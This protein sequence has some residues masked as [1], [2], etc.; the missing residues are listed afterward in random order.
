MLCLCVIAFG[1]YALQADAPKVLDAGAAAAAKTQ[2]SS[3]AARPTHLSTDTNHEPGTKPATDRSE[4]HSLEP[5]AKHS[6][7]SERQ[8][9]VTTPQ[10]AE[11]SDSVHALTADD[12][13]VVKVS[14]PEPDVTFKEIDPAT[15]SEETI[16]K[17]A[18]GD[19]SRY[20]FVEIDVASLREKISNL[21]MDDPLHIELFPG[22]VVSPLPGT[23]EESHNVGDDIL[24]GGILNHPCSAF[25][26]SVNAQ[27][28]LSVRSFHRHAPIFNVE[29]TGQD[30]VYA[31]T[32]S[33]NDNA[34]TCDD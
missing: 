8:S 7:S 20:R 21:T 6:L 13:P 16:K 19:H 10:T 12:A 24:T 25:T 28:T 5:P 11:R 9:G 3:A 34:P 27:G 18:A 4:S 33:F 15:L 22:E 2:S 23:P 30:S 31:I 14:V 26:M 1:I 32:Q 17:Y 29:H